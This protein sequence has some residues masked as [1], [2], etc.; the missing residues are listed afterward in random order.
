MSDPILVAIICEDMHPKCPQ[1]AL[2]YCMNKAQR[3]LNNGN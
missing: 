3:G 1:E 2:D